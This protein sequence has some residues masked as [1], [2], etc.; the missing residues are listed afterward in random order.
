MLHH[1]DFMNVIDGNLSSR[2]K[3]YTGEYLD[4]TQGIMQTLHPG[5]KKRLTAR[6]IS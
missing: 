4:V 6:S 1:W 2:N 5:Q 3:H